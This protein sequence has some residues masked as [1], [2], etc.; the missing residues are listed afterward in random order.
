MHSLLANEVLG[1]AI[2]LGKL[3]V[4][5]YDDTCNYLEVKGY[6]PLLA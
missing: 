1:A 5:G 3:V 2:N 4:L 6:F